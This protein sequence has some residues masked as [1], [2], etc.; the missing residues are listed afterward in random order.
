MASTRIEWLLD[1]KIPLVLARKFRG[2]LSY[3]SS[4]LNQQT[5]AKQNQSKQGKTGKNR[6]KQG[7]GKAG[8]INLGQN[9]K[10]Q[11]KAGQCN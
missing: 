9:W 11:G 8:Q 4:S 1:L 5:K 7:K 2:R 10:M 3:S 6:V